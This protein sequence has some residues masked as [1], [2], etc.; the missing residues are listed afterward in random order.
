MSLNLNKKKERQ[1]QVKDELINWRLYVK[2]LKEKIEEL[3]TE[4]SDALSKVL[5][6][7]EEQMRINTKY[8]IWMDMAT[9]VTGAD[10]FVV[11]AHSEVRLTKDGELPLGDSVELLSTAYVREDI[12]DELY[13]GSEPSGLLEVVVDDFGD[14]LV[15]NTR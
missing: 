3:K 8:Y 14:Y 13:Y 6:L 5:L 11:T 10:F 15:V 12:G 1:Q 4:S 7:R 2:D 9:T